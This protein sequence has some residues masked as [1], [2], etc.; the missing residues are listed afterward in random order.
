MAYKHIWSARKLRRV[1][2]YKN[3]VSNVVFF[4]RVCVCGGGGGGQKI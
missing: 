3:L 1:P 2:F 4:V